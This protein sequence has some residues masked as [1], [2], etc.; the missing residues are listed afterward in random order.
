[1]SRIQA[2]TRFIFRVIA[3]LRILSQRHVDEP[4]TSRGEIFVRKARRWR[5][6][7]H[8]VRNTAQY[9]RILRKQNYPFNSVL[10]A[11][12]L[13]K[14]KMRIISTTHHSRIQ[15]LSILDFLVAKQQK[16]TR[17][18]FPCLHEKIDIGAF[19]KSKLTRNQL[20]ALPHLSIFT[21]GDRYI[22]LWQ[23]RYIAF[24]KNL[25]KTIRYIHAERRG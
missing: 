2:L 7:T 22:C 8:G 18:N 14:S 19:L 6:H 1:M 23:I 17:E 10:S 13:E 24:L 15:Y 25:Q 21:F 5:S 3:F 16:S 12:P 4:H 11:S 9:I 20:H